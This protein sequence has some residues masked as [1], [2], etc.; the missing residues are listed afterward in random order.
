MDV[1]PS[2]PTLAAQALA[3]KCHLAVQALANKGT[4]H[5]RA[6]VAWLVS[7]S[8]GGKSVCELSSHLS[9]CLLCSM[10]SLLM[11]LTNCHVVT[12]GYL[13]SCFFPGPVR[14]LGLMH[15]PWPH[16]CMQCRPWHLAAVAAW[17]PINRTN[18]PTDPTIQVAM[19]TSARTA[20]TAANRRH[21]HPRHPLEPAEPAG[22]IGHVGSL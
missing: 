8:L 17:I 1:S 10:A 3:D 18:Q 7:W 22:C 13:V 9:C 16:S 12:C 5:P 4:P 2:E 19:C 15:V 14:D 6:D 11:C 20:C 21:W